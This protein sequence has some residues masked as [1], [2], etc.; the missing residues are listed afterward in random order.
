MAS[1][2]PSD[3]IQGMFNNQLLGFK[4]KHQFEVPVKCV[5]VAEIPFLF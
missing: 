1:I 3:D 4:A 2:L 5:C